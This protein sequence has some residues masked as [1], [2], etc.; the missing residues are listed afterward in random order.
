MTEQYPLTIDGQLLRQQRLLLLGLHQ[1]LSQQQRKDLLPTVEGL[2]T[3]LDAIADHAFDTYDI[4]GLI[5]ESDSVPVIDSSSTSVPAPNR[6]A[7]YDLSLN[8]ICSNQLY[9]DIA[10]AHEDADARGDDVIVV[11]V[12]LKGATRG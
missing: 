3:L 10:E 12:I 6:W 11:P 4:Y 5:E 2:I 1:Y 7:L 9:A 8:E